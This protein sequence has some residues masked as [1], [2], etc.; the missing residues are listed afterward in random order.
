MYSSG[1]ASNQV[2]TQRTEIK[3][4][5]TV[6]KVHLACKE[7]QDAEFCIFCDA[8]ACKIL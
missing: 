7:I 8:H 3:I 2:G 6:K 5:N 1:V 4:E